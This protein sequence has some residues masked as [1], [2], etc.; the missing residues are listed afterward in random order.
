MSAA[1]LL[2]G[3]KL[4]TCAMDRKLADDAIGEVVLTRQMPDRHHAL[5]TL[6]APVAMA[7]YLKVP[8]DRTLPLGCIDDF[9]Q[10]I[11]LLGCN[12]QALT[13]AIGEAARLV[14]GNWHSVQ[15]LA[16]GPL[17]Q[18]SLSHAAA[19]DCVQ[20]WASPRWH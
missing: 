10:A 16:H 14:Y 4:R 5:V 3:H 20:G 13:E 12:Q 17:R 11:P 18:C 9:S 19:L 15:R 2:L 6:A 8:L 7:A 1:A